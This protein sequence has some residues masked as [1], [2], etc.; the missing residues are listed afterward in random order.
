[1]S[2]FSGL[3]DVD[4]TPYTL[5]NHMAE[6]RLIN[7]RSRALSSSSLR[8]LSGIPT[9][10]LTSGCIHNCVYCYSRGYSQYPE[11]NSIELYANTAEQVQQELPRKR[12]KPIAVYFCPSCDPFQPIPEVES[13]A[14]ETMKI[15]L[16]NSIGVQFVTKGNI[17]EKFLRMF[18]THSH[19]IHSQIGL[20]SC[21]ENLLKILEPKAASIN[22]RLNTL[23]QLME[24]GIEVAVR[25]DPLIAGITDTDESLHN[26][27]S[28]IGTLGVKEIA[29]SYMFLRPAIK[30]SLTK[31]IN[32]KVLLNKTL[33]AY[34]KNIRLPIAAPNSQTWVLPREM[35]RQG[36][37]RIKNI[38]DGYGINVRICG[39]KNP[40]ITDDSCNII[41]LNKNK[42]LPLFNE[43]QP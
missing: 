1:M 24:I 19:L 13:Q 7:R 2:L 10:N 17:P 3:I 25:A 20:T 18:K 6:V 5:L 35:R 37:G 28:K 27:L 11:N 31:R 30:S 33:S 39:C 12:K 23:S 9:I 32:D 4:V 22:Q 41:H 36:F 15:L 21:N 38:A 26:L 43:P 8:C 40:H 14:F 34:S 16:E 42:E 29:V